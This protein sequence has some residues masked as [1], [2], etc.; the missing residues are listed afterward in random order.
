MTRTYATEK[1][2]A[3][4]GAGSQPW[5]QGLSFNYVNMHLQLLPDVM[6]AIVPANTP[7]F[8]LYPVLPRGNVQIEDGRTLT[9]HIPT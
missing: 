1:I 8:T 4:A 3:Y 5:Q 6:T 9:P 7:I 2:A